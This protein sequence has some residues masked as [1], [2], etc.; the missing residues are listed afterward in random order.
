M[1]INSKE[2]FTM[3][4]RIVS[5]VTPICFVFT[6]MGC[7]S[8]KTMVRPDLPPDRPLT[9]VA[10]VTTDKIHYVFEKAKTAGGAETDILGVLT[11][12]TISGYVQGGKFK[13][14]PLSQVHALTVERFD[15]GKTVFASLLL[16]GAVAGIIV[17]IVSSENSNPAPKPTTTGQK[18]CPFI[19]S[20]DGSRYVLDGEP[21]GGAFCEGLKRTDLCQLEHLQPV[22]GAYRILLRNELDETQ[23]VDQFKL[24]VVDHV[25]GV[26]VLPDAGGHMYMIAN[27]IPPSRAV[28]QTGRDITD[29]LSQSDDFLWETD[30]RSKDP[31][32]AGDLRDTLLLTFPKPREAKSVNL[33]VNGGTALWGSRMVTGM[34]EIRGEL[35]PEWFEALQSPESMGQ[36]DFW[37]NREEILRLQ[38]KVRVGGSWETRGVIRGNG[39][40]V[41][42]ERTIPIRL[43]GVEGDSLEIQIA[44]PAGFWQLNR[45]AADYGREDAPSVREIAAD[46]IVG[47]DGSDLMDLLQSNDGRYYVMSVTG[48]EARLVFRVPP[49]TPGMEQTVFAKVAGYYD[50]HLAASGEPRLEEIRRIETE[51]GY[52]AQ[53]ALREFHAWQVRASAARVHVPEKSE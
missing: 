26:Q 38:I 40:Y 3:P 35:L 44:P 4:T 46:S 43:D 33:V 50:M 29:W 25:P 24:Q 37:D 32:R 36:I 22:Q 19:Y 1:W 18:S 10:V 7:Y 17:A 51:P 34:T 13:E 20:G 47:D 23:Y 6:L 48:E 21:L 15:V 31:T 11:D 14:I 45:F 53:F 39:P 8:E 41:T 9:V 2:N 5:L 30:L 16:G 27:P 52:P 28:D 42:E 12:S 49:P